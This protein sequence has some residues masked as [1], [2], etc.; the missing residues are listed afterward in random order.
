MLNTVTAHDVALYSTPVAPYVAV[1]GFDEV[2]PK[3]VPLRVTV[4]PPGVV[5]APPAADTA[6]GVYDTVPTDTALGCTP[7]VTSQTCDVPTPATLVHRISV[8]AV[9]TVQLVAA[10]VVPDAPYVALTT[11]PIVGPK[12]VPVN[13]IT[14]PPLVD[15]LPPPTTPVIAGGMYESVPPPPLERALD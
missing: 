13:V 3:L 11:W 1:I 12:F 2:G 8:S 10:Y 14:D 15:M 5:I 6:G 9:F 7:T 4:L